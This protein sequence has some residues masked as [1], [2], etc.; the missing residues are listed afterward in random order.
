[1]Q[2][3]WLYVL[4]HL[5]GTGFSKQCTKNL[6]GNISTFDIEKWGAENFRKIMLYL[7]ISITFL[8][9]FQPSWHSGLNKCSCSKIF[10]DL[11]PTQYQYIMDSGVKICCTLLL[12]LIWIS[13]NNI[14]VLKIIT[15]YNTTHF[16]IFLLTQHVFHL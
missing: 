10:F 6:I 13:S 7:L 5:F 3:W 12:T 15:Y 16:P 11:V 1:M 4:M 2:N 9:N 8:P 14:S